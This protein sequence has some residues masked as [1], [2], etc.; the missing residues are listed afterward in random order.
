MHNRDSSRPISGTSVHNRNPSAR[1]RPPRVINEVENQNAES[2]DIQLDFKQTRFDLPRDDEEDQQVYEEELQQ[3]GRTDKEEMNNL[4]S[5]IS[6]S[7]AE[8]SMFDQ[9]NST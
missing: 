1:N 6:R 7:E 4:R 2:I 8:P 3:T 5:Q 9:F